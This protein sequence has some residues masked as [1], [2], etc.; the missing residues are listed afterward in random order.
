MVSTKHAGEY[1]S[2]TA[3]AD[4]LI[5]FVF[6]TITRESILYAT[7]RQAYLLSPLY[8]SRISSRTVLFLA[9]PQSYLCKKK[10]SKVFGDSVK[11][12]WITSDCSKLQK[13]VKKRDNLAYS[14]EAA[15]TRYIRKAH[16]AYLKS[17]GT[18]PMDPESSTEA[19]PVD[20]EGKLAD[21]PPEP[22]VERP[23]H[24]TRFLFGQRVDTIDWLRSQLAE[25]MP[26]VE[27]LQ[28]RNRAGEVKPVS[29][30]FIEF[31]TQMEAQIAY[32][33]LSHHHPFQMTPRF[34]G[35]SPD[36]VIWPAL[37]YTWWQRIIRKFLVQGFIAVLIIF[38]SIP[39]AFVGSISNITYLT[40]LLPFLRFINDLPTIVQGAISG[41]LPTVALA[42]LM[43]LAPIILR[44]EYNVVIAPMAC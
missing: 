34:I 24:R 42:M 15:E 14:L 29:A 41:V 19:S 7:L 30:A 27:K 11:R 25:V 39:S 16:A 37:Q 26:Q 38:W 6:C 28:E 10:L 44:C 4:L 36:Q 31:T 8:A 20:C 22:S 9:V 32:Q 12:I 40:N 1:I 23:S 3:A 43:S 35:I 2:C 21:F 17:S 5:G 13:L 18:Q 33:T